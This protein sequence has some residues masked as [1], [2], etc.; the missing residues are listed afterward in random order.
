M[1]L[2]NWVLAINC[3]FFSNSPPGL[4]S[5]VVTGLSLGFQRKP[6]YVVSVII[7]VSAPESV[8]ND[9]GVPPML[10]VIRNGGSLFA[11]TISTVL[12]H[13]FFSVTDMRNKL[14]TSSVTFLTLL[15][16]HTEAKW[17]IL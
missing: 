10:I 4:C 12:I 1:P 13:M 7:D 15:V 3:P 6:L 17:P 16:K 2:L 9:T 14:S 5:G 8:L 11:T